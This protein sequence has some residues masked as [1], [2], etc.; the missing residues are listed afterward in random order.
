MPA[1]YENPLDRRFHAQPNACWE[2]G[3]RVE[4][5]DKAGQNELNAPIPLSRRPFGPARRIG[6]RGQGSGRIPSGGRRHEPRGGRSIA[7]TETPGGETVCRDGAGLQAAEEICKLDDAAHAVLE[8]IQRPIVLLP[9]KSPSVIPEEVAPFN[10]YLGIFLPYTP[11][12]YMLLAGAGSRR[13]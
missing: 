1:E 10:R 3:P 11:L 9:K 2:C 13:W 6:R 12:H 5:W 8:S 7:G 4:L